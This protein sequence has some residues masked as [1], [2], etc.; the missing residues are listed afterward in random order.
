MTFSSFGHPI[1]SFGHPFSSFKHFFLSYLHLHTFSA[2]KMKWLGHTGMLGAIPVK[3]LDRYGPH[4]T[5]MVPTLPVWPP[6]YWYGEG[7]TG[8]AHIIPVY[9]GPYW[10]YPVTKKVKIMIKKLA[11]AQFLT[12]FIK[13]KWCFHNIVP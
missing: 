4:H 7:Q 1:S 11:G 10:S 9:W 13:R 3:L 6:A 2:W 5:G 12:I 8:V